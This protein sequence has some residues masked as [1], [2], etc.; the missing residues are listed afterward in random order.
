VVCL[1]ILKKPSE[2]NELLQLVTVVPGVESLGLRL[3]RRHLMQVQVSLSPIKLDLLIPQHLIEAKGVFSMG[4]VSHHLLEVLCLSSLGLGPPRV[5][6]STDL[7]KGFL[8][9]P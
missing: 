4:D 5:K 7:G 6:V 8:Q 1:D 9:N 2:L 3:H